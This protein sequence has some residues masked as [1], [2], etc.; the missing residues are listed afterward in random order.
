M[1]QTAL[2]KETILKKGDENGFSQIVDVMTVRLHGTS[3]GI[4][5]SG[6]HESNSPACAAGRRAAGQLLR[7]PAG[8]ITLNQLRPCPTR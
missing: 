2:H 8:Y 6:F 7:L 1:V 3:K 4:S 5:T